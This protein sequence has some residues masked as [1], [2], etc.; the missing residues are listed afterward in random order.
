[1][2]SIQLAQM[3][4]DLSDLD[5][6]Q[7]AAAALALVNANKG[8]QATAA[9]PD[10][11]RSTLKLPADGRHHHRVNSSSASAGRTASPASRFDHF[12]RRI[13]TPPMTRSS[14][15][16]GSLPGT[17]RRESEN[18]EEVDRASTLMSLYEIRAKIKQQDN[19][20]LMR[21][22]EKVQALAARQQ[23]QAAE[24]KEAHNR[25]SFPRHP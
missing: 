7:E 10:H 4:A 21:A 16:H 18:E 22:R 11:V 13:L 12:G 14:S 24:K 25:Y 5:A 20:S 9:I 19:S 8:L 23:A 6:A 3:L 2:E 1:M 17:P 15:S